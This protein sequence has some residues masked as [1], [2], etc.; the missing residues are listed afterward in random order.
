MRTTAVF[1][2]LEHEQPSAAAWSAVG[3]MAKEWNYAHVPKFLD[4]MGFLWSIKFED[5]RGPS[6]PEL[7]PKLEALQRDFNC[8]LHATSEAIYDE[9][10]Y[11]AADFVE[12]LGIS[13]EGF[14]GRPFI[15]NL[16]AALGAPV[17][18]RACGWQD[19]FSTVQKAP[20][21]I[22]ETLLDVALPG[23]GAPP[24]DGWDC[25]NLPNGH[26]LVSRRI[27][28]LF[29]EN[30]V[31]DFD[32]MPV[33]TGTSGEESQRMFQI[34]ARKFVST[35]VLPNSRAQLSVCQVCGAVRDRNVGDHSEFSSLTP[36]SWCVRKEDVAEDE[37]LS[38]HPGRGAMLYVAQRVYRLL[39]AGG[40]NG[41]VPSAVLTLC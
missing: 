40:V 16:N 26:K 30:R 39:M 33:L 9:T 27:L 4:T 5:Q 35:T 34:L 8:R 32:I 23:G 37:I 14:A 1:T 2:F 21:A 20:F 38:R 28:S 12:I 19:M 17:P 22:D 24:V 6:F 18:C 7:L 3:E 29:K 41:I 11:L 25:V 31:S 15:L 13:L 36:A 10:D